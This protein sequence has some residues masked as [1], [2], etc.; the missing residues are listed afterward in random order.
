MTE[1]LRVKMEKLRAIAP[2]LNR[3]TDQ[4]IAA[5]QA[6]EAFLNGLSLGIE[7]HTSSFGQIPVEDSSPDDGRMIVELTLA[8]GRLRGDFSIHVLNATFREDPSVADA[9][10]EVA[11]EKTPWR[12]LSREFKLMSFAKLP[13]LLDDIFARAEEL[14]EKAEAAGETVGSML[15][16]LGIPD[17]DLTVFVEVNANDRETFPEGQRRGV[18]TALKREGFPVTPE[19]VAKMK[20]IEERGGEISEI[21][22]EIDPAARTGVEA[23]RRRRQ[24]K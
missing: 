6:V 17:P 8:Y 23:I 4:A 1:E 22:K 20:R 16:S 14:A 10:I 19:N 12:G 21:R 2:R 24:G 5:V 13:E 18:E 11:R 3:T 15:S 7:G 9:W